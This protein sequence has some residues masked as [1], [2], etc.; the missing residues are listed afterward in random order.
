[1]VTATVVRAPHREVAPAAAPATVTPRAAGSLGLAPSMKFCERPEN[2]PCAAIPQDMRLLGPIV[3]VALAPGIALANH[4]SGAEIHDHRSGSGDA[5]PAP[6]VHDHRSSSEEHATVVR[7]HRSPGGTGAYVDDEVIVDDGPAP[8]SGFM[9]PHGPSWTFEFGG[10]AR[11]FRGP[12]FSRSGTVETTGG[13]NV[14]YGL[15]SGASSDGDTAAGAF[16]MR[17]TVPVSEHLYA[18]AELELGG[19]TRSPVQLMTDAPDIHISSR[20]MVGAAAVAGARARQGIAELDGEVAGGMR[21]VSMTV[22]SL[23]AGE[24][25][26]SATESSLSAEVEARVRGALWLSPHV[27]LAAQAGVGV[28]DQSDV[29][30][31]LSIGLAAHAFGEAH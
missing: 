6:V 1:M 25:D 3:L 15:A 17:A 9:S 2:G 5:H 7:D 10:V 27:F 23:D 20:A 12:G 31:G 8:S 14:G 16:A 29:N 21:V 19:L 28:F 24:D 13:D 22:Q 26:P 30:V 18:G 4:H 11:R